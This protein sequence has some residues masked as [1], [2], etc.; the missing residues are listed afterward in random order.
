MKRNKG[1]LFSKKNTLKSCKIRE[2][3]RLL[4]EIQ[5]NSSSRQNNFSPIKVCSFPEK[6]T[7]VFKKGL[8]KGGKNV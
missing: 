2:I 3:L 1:F 6:I 4:Y 5:S 7:Q 8:S